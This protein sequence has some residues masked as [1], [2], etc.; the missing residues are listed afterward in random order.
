MARL[1]LGKL[2]QILESIGD[3]LVPHGRVGNEGN[4]LQEHRH[5]SILLKDSIYCRH[6]YIASHHANSVK[7]AVRHI[8]DRFHCVG[9]K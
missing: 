3:D 1:L 4:I 9:D 8:V 2:F 6:R 7:S 5:P